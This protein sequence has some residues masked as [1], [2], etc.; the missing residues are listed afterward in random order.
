MYQLLTKQGRLWRKPYSEL[1][2][3]RTWVSSGLNDKALAVKS[4][5]GASCVACVLL[6]R[7]IPARVTISGTRLAGKRTGGISVAVVRIVAKKNKPPAGQ[8]VNST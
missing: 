5:V 4:R 6:A 3:D 2:V 1:P 7:R 8:I